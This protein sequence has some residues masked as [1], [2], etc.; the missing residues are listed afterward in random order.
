L[1]AVRTVPGD[2][3]CGIFL[4]NIQKVYQTLSYKKAYIFLSWRQNFPAERQVLSDSMT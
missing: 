4:S 1:A 3:R 2:E